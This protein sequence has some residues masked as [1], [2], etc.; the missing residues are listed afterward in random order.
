MKDEQLAENLNNLKEE[1][2]E[3]VK[4]EIK[5]SISKK[6]K[7]DI[8]HIIATLVISFIG[9]SIIPI[10]VSIYGN[11]IQATF[12]ESDIKMKR[13]EI[14]SNQYPKII[15]T[16]SNES[17]AACILIGEL[18]S[19][20]PIIDSLYIEILS[21]F[22]V[23]S[24]KDAS[25][26]LVQIITDKQSSASLK[27]KANEI[28]KEITDT[29][30][31][32]ALP[33]IPKGTGMSPIYKDNIWAIELTKTSQENIDRIDKMFKTRETYIYL[34]T[35]NNIKDRLELRMKPPWTCKDIKISTVNNTSELVLYL[36]HN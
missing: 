23:R 12:K 10:V 30:Q 25:K 29:I 31:K 19:H 2:K 35:Y 34:I 1:L 17:K 14:F 9:F 8:F 11:K 24:K 7:W 6:D 22:K 21:I 27:R 16:D 4:V 3:I 18:A 33:E 20:D 26:D 32:V 5:S 28:L 15:S 36:N 13:F